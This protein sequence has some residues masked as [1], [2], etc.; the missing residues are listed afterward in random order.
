VADREWQA[1]VLGGH[2]KSGSGAIRCAE[3]NGLTW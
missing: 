3:G 2:P 1:T